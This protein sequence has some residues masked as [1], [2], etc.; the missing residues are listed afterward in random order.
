M[1]SDKVTAYQAA[2]KIYATMKAQL[3]RKRADLEAQL[4][5][6]LKSV[7]MAKQAFQDAEKNL[8]D[9]ALADYANTGNKKLLTDIEVKVFTEYLYE[10]RRA[11]SWAREH[12]FCIKLDDDAF[13]VICKYES[14]RPE[15]VTVKHVPRVQL[16]KGLLGE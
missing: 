11:A 8:R 7:A 14:A 4:T 3:D 10:P 1:L 2:A 6:D 15:F 16:G 13:R 5:M 12:S 9:E